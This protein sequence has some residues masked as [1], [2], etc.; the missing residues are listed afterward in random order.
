VW[1]KASKEERRKEKEKEKEKG[2]FSKREKTL[3]QE[4]NDRGIT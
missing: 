1:I 4:K 2:T 3:Q